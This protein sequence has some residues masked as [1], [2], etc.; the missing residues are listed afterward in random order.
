M[1]TQKQIEN[2]GLAI[3]EP[4]VD[5]I[6][7][8]TEKHKERK[9]QEEEINWNKFPIVDVS[10]ANDKSWKKWDK[11]DEHYN[12]NADKYAEQCFVCA[13]GIKNIKNSYIIRGWGNPTSLVHKKDHNELENGAG[14]GGDMGCYFTGSCCGSKIKKYLKQNGYNHKDYIYKY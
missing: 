2:F 8:L 5:A 13:K 14:K 7:K 11:N 3:Y 12:W 4:L 9:K 6:E 1:K 10:L